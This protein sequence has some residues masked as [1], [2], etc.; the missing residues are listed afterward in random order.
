MAALAQSVTLGS[1][2]VKHVIS[3]PQS[4]VICN[5][6]RIY[7]GAFCALPG[8]NANT[9]CRGYLIA[10][11]DE[12]NVQWAGY[13]IAQSWTGGLITSAQSGTASNLN[14]VLGNTAAGNGIN[15]QE[16]TVETGPFVLETTVT[17]VSA[18]SD[19]WRTLVYCNTDNYADLSTTA[20]VYAP[21][22]GRV[23]YWFSSTRCQVWF[24]GMKRMVSLT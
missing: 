20:S 4:F 8:A 6:N 5:S 2:I 24:H 9:S 7:S 11:E 1:D 19:V 23:Y 10:W 3:D 15:G 16:I 18:M 13:A 22:I 17:G 12:V 21:S 14:S